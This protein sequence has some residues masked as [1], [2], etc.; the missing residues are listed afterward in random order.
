MNCNFESYL[1]VLIPSLKEN[2]IINKKTIKIILLIFAIKDLANCL[3]PY[4][5]AFQGLKILLAGLG[6]RALA[7]MMP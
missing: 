2:Y 4:G 3:N 5:Y 1:T 6:S 7:A